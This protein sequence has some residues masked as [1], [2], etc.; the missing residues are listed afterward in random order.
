[1]AIRSKSFDF[2]VNLYNTT[3]TDRF[4]FEN[5]EYNWRHKDSSVPRLTIWKGSSN[6]ISENIILGVG[7]SNFNNHLVLSERKE[8]LHWM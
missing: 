3:W 5:G 2:N 6:I 4:L 1:M 7:Q 8:G